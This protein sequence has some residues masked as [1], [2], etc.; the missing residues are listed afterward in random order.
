MPSRLT[1]IVLFL[2][3]LAGACNNSGKGDASFCDTACLND[4]LK[5]I[6]AEHSLKPYVYISAKNCM[7]DTIL[8]SYS[9]MGINRKMG[10][11]DLLNVSVRLNKSFIN[12]VI[13]DT[14]YAWVMF[15]DCSNGRGYLL[16][17][18]YNKSKAIERKSSAINK[19]DPKFSV[20]DGLVSYTDRGNIFVEDM[21]TGKQTMMTF[22]KKLETDYDV[23][24]ETIDS[25]NITRK[26]IWVKV[27]IENEW[28]E[29]EKNI[30]L[31]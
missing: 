23:I 3:V 5:F 10:L 9:G 1:A 26:R 12:S 29:L 22:G 24:H 15:N 31:Q 19:L 4:S 18:P 13:Y 11:H 8:W 30:D 27:R 16:K 14:S 28:K 21:A 7:A 25:V 17:L 20:E 2:A 6:K